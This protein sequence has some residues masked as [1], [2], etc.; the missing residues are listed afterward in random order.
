MRRFYTSPMPAPNADIEQL[1]ARIREEAATLG[2]TRFGVSGIA[3]DEDA[4]HLRTWLQEG[5]HGTMQWM[6]AHGEKRMRPDELIPGTVSVIS[7]RRSAFTLRVSCRSLICSAS[8]FF[9]VL[10]SGLMMETEPRDAGS[11]FSAGVPDA[12]R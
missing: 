1:I 7:V 8:V 2:F 5:L 6:A 11:V 12:A 3:V 4:G 9:T 10:S